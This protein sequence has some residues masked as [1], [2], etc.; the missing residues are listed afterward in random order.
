MRQRGMRKEGKR[1]A[2]HLCSLHPLS[3]YRRSCD[4]QPM[5]SAVKDD[6]ILDERSHDDCV[7]RRVKGQKED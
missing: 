7:S 4:T 1:N 6:Y 2:A 3:L 5:L